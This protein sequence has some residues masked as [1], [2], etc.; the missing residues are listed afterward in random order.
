MTL[1][2]VE[3][4]RMS[5]DDIDDV[6]VLERLSF[7][8]PWSREAFVEELTKNKFALYISARINGR[9]IGYAG[10]WKVCD[11]GHITNVAVHPEYRRN[12]VGRKLV[13]GLIELAKKEEIS[14]MT[15]EVRRSNTV[16]QELYSKYGFEVDGYRKE[17]YSDNGEDAVIMWKGNM[18]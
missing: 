8:I 7:I 2:N 3:I 10:M 17:Y 13:E 12:G 16:A 9:V 1:G 5:L 11:E 15:L 4:S 14:R 18:Q 6:I